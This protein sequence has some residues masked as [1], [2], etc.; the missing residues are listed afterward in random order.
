MTLI[1]QAAGV[2]NAVGAN[3]L[4]LNTS[5]Q[6]VINAGLIEATGAGGLTIQGTAVNNS[7]GTLK[8][9]TGSVVTLQNV[10]VIGR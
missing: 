8:A 7:G 10:N 5:S 6:T 1:N 9:N 4:L 2:I 3:A